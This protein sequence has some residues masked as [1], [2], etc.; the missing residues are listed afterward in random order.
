MELLA[1]SNS[2][3]INYLLVFSVPQGSYRR[4][5]TKGRG[6]TDILSSQNSLIVRNDLVILCNAGDNSV[7][8]FRK[9]DVGNYQFL[10]KISSGGDRPVS[11][12]TY[13]NYILI[14]NENSSNVGVISDVLEYS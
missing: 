9:M 8:N 5:D 13:Q 7:S 11:L 2:S 14:L 12:T 4:Y 3:P 6:S 10:N 1:L